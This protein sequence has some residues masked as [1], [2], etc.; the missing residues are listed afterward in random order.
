MKPAISNNIDTLYQDAI[1]NIQQGDLV[2]AKTLAKKILKTKSMNA[3]ANYLLGI[4]AAQN[5]KYELACKHFKLAIKSNN[6]QSM[7][8][9]NFGVVSGMS[10]QTDQAVTAYEQAIKLNPELT[11][12]HNNLGTL[13]FTTGQPDKALSAYDRVLQ[14]QPNN[15]ITH[16]NRGNAL[17]EL[18]KSDDAIKAYQRAIELQ[19][20]NAESHYNLGI[21]FESMG[22]SGDA[23]NAYDEAVKI[24]PELTEAYCNHGVVL[25]D[26]GRPGEAEKS[27]RRAIELKPDYTKA[28]SNLLFSLNYRTD[29]TK[30][31]LYDAHCDWDQKHSQIKPL[32]LPPRHRRTQHRLRIAYVSPDFRNH[33]VAFFFSPLLSEHNREDFEIY[34]YSNTSCTDSVTERIKSKTD[35]WRSIVNMP[36]KDVAKL[37]QKDN[38]D[39]L[40]DLAGHT[41]GNRLPIFTYRP[42]PIQITWLGYPNTTGLQTMDYRLTDNIADPIGDTDS[43]YT[44]KLIRLDTGFLCYQPPDSAPPTANAP[45]LNVGHIT[46]GSFN[47]MAKINS[48]VISVWS[49]ILC[50]LPESRLLLKNNG[51]GDDRNKERILNLFAEH[52]IDKE[53]IDLYGRLPKQKDHLDLYRKIDIS[54]DTFPYNGTTT[55]CEAL[56]MGIPV[57]TLRGNQHA[58]RVGA[59]IL[60]HMDCNEWIAST[61]ASYIETAVKLAGDRQGLAELRISQ[62]NRMMKSTLLDAKTFAT[63]IENVYR[64]IWEEYLDKV[65]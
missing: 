11:E 56:W 17:K 1:N 51:L 15:A 45:C 36:D 44:E 2:K 23:L 8:F 35:H 34:C 21:L 58:S 39:I 33:S 6:Q 25:V 14:L 65:H 19:P 38:I 22:Y 59:S 24:N 3:E 49:E 29:L 30:K 37:I 10:G 47:V 26:L 48:E 4:I 46:F 63:T 13:F 31:E 5:S 62:R 16:G 54:L 20:K 64:M 50:N 7:Y 9:Y 42:A 40:V 43:L 52:G 28:H 57:I 41:A 12:A 53:R 18:G 60:A 32:S 61:T 27:Y 55:S